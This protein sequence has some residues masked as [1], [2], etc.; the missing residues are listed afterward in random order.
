MHN[1]QWDTY[2]LRSIQLGGNENILKYQKE[3]GIENYPISKKYAHAIM[4]W[5]QRGHKKQMDGL[6]H[7]F[8]E[9]KPAKDFN[10]QLD[11]AE[12]GLQ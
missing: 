10:E 9:Q 2:H 5:Y 11:R 8:T 12:K 7:L 3:Y 4:N 6:G 1:E